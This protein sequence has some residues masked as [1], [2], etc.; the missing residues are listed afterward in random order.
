M[1]HIKTPVMA[2]K[3]DL[4]QTINYICSELFAEAVAASLYGTKV[5]EEAAENLLSSI[6]I[7]KNDFVKRISHP[8]PGMEPKKY[9]ARLVSDFNHRVSDIIDQIGNLG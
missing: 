1:T 5:S 2:K 4:K 3:K 7:T 8:Q 9:Y 6:I